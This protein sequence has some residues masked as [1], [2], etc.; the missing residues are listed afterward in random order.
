MRGNQHPVR[1]VV[2]DFDYTLA[3]SS[4]GV[5]LCANQ[6]LRELGLPTARPEAIRATIGLSLEASLVAL[7]G[8]PYAPLGAA[9]RAAFIRKADQVMADNTT[10]LPGARETI[11]AL[12]DASVALA[13][14]TNKLSHRVR[15]VLHREGLDGAFLSIVGAGDAVGPDGVAV[16]KPEP[17][18]LL[19]AL[20]Q[21]GTTTEKSVYVGDS[22]TD[23]ETASRAGVRFVASL[24][25]VTPPEAFELYPVWRTVPNVGEV[26]DLIGL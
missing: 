9:Y 1:A 15:A 12:A 4:P 21:L 16:H 8:E 2:F 7:A 11:E 24:T 5:I 17:A 18:P 23:A 13:I 6:A 26:P 22:V 10:L 14:V 25:G 3:D 19:L 20:G